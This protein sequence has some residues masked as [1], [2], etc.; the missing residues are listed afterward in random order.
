PP[1]R[2]ISLLLFLAIGALAFRGIGLIIAAVSNSTAESNVLVQVL[3]MPMLMLSGAMFPATIL[4]RAAQVAAQFVPASYLVSGVQGILT[5]REPLSANWKSAVAL[6]I[7][8]TI[9][10]FVATRLFRWEKDEKLKSSAKLWVAAVLLPFVALGVYQFRSSEQIVKNRMLWRELQRGD[11][12]LIRNA[13]IFVGDGRVIDSGSLLVRKGKIEA[14]Y[15]GRGPDESL[16]KAEVIEAAGETVL[17]GLVDVHVHIGA[18]G[19]VYA[20]AKDF[21]A[22][23]IAER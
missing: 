16:V 5:Q 1:D 6:L 15:E 22:E 2:P 13:K 21:A 20:D 10:V 9:A 18:P 8:L 19:G 11:V 7:T 3:Y 12:F 4:P 14:V 17:P 23:H